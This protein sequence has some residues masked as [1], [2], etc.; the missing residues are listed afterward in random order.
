MPK[1]SRKARDKRW[2]A[3]RSAKRV[4]LTFLPGDLARKA[5]R[6]LL[7]ADGDRCGICNR[8]VRLFADHDH[9][10][11]RHRGRLCHPCNAAIGLMKDDPQRLRQAAE[12]LEN[13]EI[14]IT[15]NE[16]GEEEAASESY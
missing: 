8:K 5:F 3:L 1:P 2:H 12:Y 15:D 10:R 6:R 14:Y 7:Q 9:R 13:F 16:Y 4:G 11:A